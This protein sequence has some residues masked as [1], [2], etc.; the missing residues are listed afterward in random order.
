MITHYNQNR[1]K[2]GVIALHQK[3]KATSN[4]LLMA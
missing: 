3:L 2:S 1:G 4:F